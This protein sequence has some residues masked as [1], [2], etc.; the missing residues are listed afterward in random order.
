VQEPGKAT[1]IGGIQTGYA[2]NVWQTTDGLN[3]SE[4]SSRAQFSP[5]SSHQ[6][7]E[8]NGEM[9][10][11]GG[12]AT[13]GRIA[14][15]ATNELW[16]SSDGVNWSRVTPNGAIFSPRSA[17]GAAVFNN[18]LWVIGGTSNPTGASG[19]DVRMNDVWS[20]ADGITW[21]QEPTPGFTPRSGFGTVAF[22]GKLWVIGGCVS[23]TNCL[24]DVWSSVDGVAWTNEV[25][26]APFSE[27]GVGAIVFNN[28]LWVLGGETSA[29][30]PIDDAWRSIDGIN[31]TLQSRGAH[32]S[33][34]TRSVFQV[35]NGRL[36]VVGG[37]SNGNYT[38][39]VRYNDVW[40]SADGL[41]WRQDLAN[42]PFSPRS[43]SSLIAHNNELWL[44]GGFNADVLNDVWR[45]TDGVNWRVGFS[46]DIAAP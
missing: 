5:R 40:S 30:V 31:W 45:S 41:T 4:L 32:A 14:D 7:I 25:L 10:I 33:P 43:L 39:G 21:Q 18:R 22:N 34:R 24:N 38:T 44:I 42:G 26:S 8:F 3:W 20:T 27:R 2:N 19:I 29:G 12:F 36:Y 37:V 15:R 28:A 11:V 9:W 17:H 46:T 16:R 13:D 35:L 23:A 6:G 1:L